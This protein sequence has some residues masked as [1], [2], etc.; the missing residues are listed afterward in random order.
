MRFR[1][2]E[3]DRTATVPGVPVTESAGNAG[4]LP[5]VNGW[6]DDAVAAGVSVFA[7]DGDG[8]GTELPAGTAAGA[9]F[10]TPT[11]GALAGRGGASLRWVCAIMSALSLI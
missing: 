4:W 7:S 2:G 3:S 6:A 10:C 9:D 5:G 1:A 11:T 8:S